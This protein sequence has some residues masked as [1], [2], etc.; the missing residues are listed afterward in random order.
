MHVDVWDPWVNAAEARREYDIEPVPVPEQG[1]YQAIVLAVAHEQFSELGIDKIRAF[2]T[3]DGI[4]F[5]VKYLFP[6]D[7]TDG[8]L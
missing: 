2:G 4:V 5:D 3:P 1:A 8:R 7:Q 6:S